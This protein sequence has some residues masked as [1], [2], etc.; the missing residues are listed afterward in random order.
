VTCLLI[1]VVGTV[2]FGIALP[3]LTAGLTGSQAGEAAM[4]YLAFLPFGFLALV[5][6]A[7]LLV[8]KARELS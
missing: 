5:F 1:F 7:I 6:G 8:L 3:L 4:G 2:G